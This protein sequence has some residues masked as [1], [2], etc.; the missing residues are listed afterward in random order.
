MMRGKVTDSDT[1]RT[2]LFG[3]EISLERHYRYAIEESSVWERFYAP[4]PLKE[5]TVLDIGAG[6]GETAA[7]YFSK[8]ASKVTAIEPN[9]QASKLLQANA[10]ANSWNLDSICDVF[11][12]EHLSIPHDF[13][14]IDCEGGEK[15][16]LENGDLLGPCVIESHS[17]L[18]T[19][20][21]AKRFHFDL[22]VAPS[23][24]HPGTKLLISLR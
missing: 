15:N 21:L 17:P 24:K 1:V 2:R 20:E 7:F 10:M 4:I 23:E 22:I 8:G 13:V 12:V 19:E 14:K 18:I 16:L 3:Y 11:K 6:C 5:K 9:P